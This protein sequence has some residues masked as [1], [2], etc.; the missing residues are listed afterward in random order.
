VDEGEIVLHLVCVI[1]SLCY[2][3]YYV[4]IYMLHRKVRREK[5]RK[6]QHRKLEAGVDVG[7]TRKA[8]KRNV[9]KN[10]RCEITVAVDLS[11]DDL[12]SDK[13]LF[14]AFVTLR[15]SEL[16]DYRTTWPW[17]DMPSLIHFAKV[18]LHF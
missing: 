5:Q 16:G 12:M 17:K 13:V 2:D 11:F 10:S 4:S 8:L 18:V 3:I 15:C 9:M 7:P 1:L 6:Q 14:L